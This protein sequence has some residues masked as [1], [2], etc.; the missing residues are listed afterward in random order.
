MNTTTSNGTLAGIDF[1]KATRVYSG[2]VGCACGCRGNYSETPRA[3]KAGINKLLRLVAAGAEPD[4]MAGT[5]VGVTHGNS[6]SLV[7]YFD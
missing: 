2:A 4:V 7:V 1:A 3:I 5:Y 6:R